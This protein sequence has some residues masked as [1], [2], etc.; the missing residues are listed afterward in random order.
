MDIKDIIIE[1]NTLPKGTIVY[2]NIKGKQQ[3]YLQWS[4]KGKTK[5]KYLKKDE[6]EYILSQIERRN[7]LNK[8]YDRISNELFSKDEYLY[9]SDNQKQY[10]TLNEQPLI[11]KKNQVNV[12][13]VEREYINSKAYHD[14]FEKL[15][16][17]KKVYERL[18]KESG[19]L[20]ENVDGINEEKMIAINARTGELIIDNLK[21]DGIS[22]HTF[23]TQEEYNRIKS[24]NDYIILIHNH[25]YNR[26][27]SGR[28][29]ATY[30]FD[31][32]TK[33]SIILCHDGDIYAIVKANPE[34][35]EIYDMFYEELNHK[36][37][38]SIAKTLALR[39][40]EALN[41]NNKQYEIW[42]L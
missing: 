20:L 26:P 23:F 31:E 15:P 22:E 16:V 33:I 5:S 11:S 13:S 10:N 27:P 24:C 21:R 17:S 38:E 1:L 2:K 12:F 7:Y 18:Y 32:K 37:E 14:K 40:L 34:V 19:R 42:R 36:Y 30:A 25:T 8:E 6:R 4:E 28:D 3:P 29:I 39:R 35:R 41:E 9:I